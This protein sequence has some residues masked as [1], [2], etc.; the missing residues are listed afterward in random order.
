M[1][2]PAGSASMSSTSRP[3]EAQRA[4]RYS[5]VAEAPGEPWVL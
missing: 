4:A 3:S 2:P 1:E 5:A